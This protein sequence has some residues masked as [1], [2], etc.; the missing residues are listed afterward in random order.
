[1]SDENK[2]MWEA[3][4]HSYVIADIYGTYLQSGIYHSGAKS[5]YFSCEAELC[6]SAGVLL[7]AFCVWWIPAPSFFLHVLFAFFFDWRA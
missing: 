3:D 2:D 4:R 5:F 1:M 6:M 7:A